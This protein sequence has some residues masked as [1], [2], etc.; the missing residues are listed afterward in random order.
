MKKGKKL[1]IRIRR[2]EKTEEVM[3]CEKGEENMK[4]KR[5]GAQG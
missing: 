1:R 3:K 5:K 4:H 2:R